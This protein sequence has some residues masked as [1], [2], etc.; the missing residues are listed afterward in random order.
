MANAVVIGGG[1]IGL[2][3]A[4]VLS[5]QGLE[6]VVLDRDAPAP[7]EPGRAW[8]DWGRRSV[9]QFRQVHY[10]Q[11]AGRRLLSE[12][13]PD[14]VD[15]LGAAG[16]VRFN[17]AALR[18]E[19]LFGGSGDVDLSAFETLTTCR[20][21]VLEF[22]FVAAARCCRG[23][24]VRNLC[25]VA[26]LVTG[27]ELIDGVP[28]VVGV[29][30]EAGETVLGD[31]IIDASGRRTSVPAMVEAA[32]GRRPLERSEDV[33][34]VYNTRYYRGADLPEYR[35]D[36]LAAVGSISILTVPGD[37]GHWSVTLY[38]SP[39]DKAMRKVR[40]GKIFDR[41]V[42]ALPL[43]AHWVDGRPVSDVVSMASTAN[44]TR[45]F[46]VDGQPCVTGLLPV[47]DA[48]GF[49]NPSIGR[50][51]TLGLKHAAAVA[52]AICPV[53]DRPDEMAASWGHA[54]RLHAQPWHDATVE[55]DR[56]RG[57][58]VEAARLGEPDPHDP[59]DPAVAGTR[60]FF[61]ATHYDPQV[62]S[63]FFEIG[64]CFALP[65][66]V[67][68]RPGVLERVIAIAS[69]NPPYVTPGPDRSQLEALLA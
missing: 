11:P 49:T 68:S 41:V 64:G 30:T 31:V 27:S 18:A 45:Q 53:L 8:E 28:H 66:E 20:R 43:H 51:I 48:W 19:V 3:M 25:A 5:Q 15:Q 33:G 55:F 7:D 38:H 6:V 24:E 10:L 54:T 44:A 14:V 16:A 17:A 52:D 26:G 22:G 50:G 12:R 62:L 58:E 61:S 34:F 42:R 37:D 36:F 29:K 46:V 35:G 56:V 23:V 47:G 59:A 39:H 40:D 57:P 67:L 32:G 2:A 69:E 21:P 63:W 65:T 9:A 13:L 1:P 4:M 60:A